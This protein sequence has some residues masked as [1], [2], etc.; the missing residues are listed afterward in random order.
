MRSAALAGSCIRESSEQAREADTLFSVMHHYA[1]GSSQPERSGRSAVLGVKV[2]AFTFTFTFSH[3]ADAFIQSDLHM[4][5]LQCIHI[6][7][8]H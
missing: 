5:D 6:L 2:K 4:C 8:L 7:H 3:L 1:T